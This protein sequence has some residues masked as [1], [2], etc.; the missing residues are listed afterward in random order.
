MSQLLQALTVRSLM[1]ESAALDQGQ[2]NEAFRKL[3]NSF[4]DE[5]WKQQLA[6]LGCAAKLPESRFEDEVDLHTTWSHEKTVWE[7]VKAQL[8]GLEATYNLDVMEIEVA[9]SAY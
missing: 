7:E 9:S 6:E 3:V 2:C 8:Q 1:I 5:G 4:S